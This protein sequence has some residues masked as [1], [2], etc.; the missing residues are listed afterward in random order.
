MSDNQPTDY[1]AIIRAAQNPVPEPPEWLTTGKQV[2][3]PEYG[4]GEVMAILGRRL[5]I[6]FV[7]EINP[8]QFKDWEDAISKGSI[9]AS[10]ANLVSST[11]NILETNAATTII[12]QQIQQIPNVGFQA[13][14]T[15]M[16]AA[17]RPRTC[18]NDR[19]GGYKKCQ[20]RD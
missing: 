10:N 7:E 14:A 5:I 1:A 12:S 2:Y 18:A 15:R 16:P 20:P 4:V 11:T 3:S 6:K 9:K 19:D 17:Y 13:I 8:T